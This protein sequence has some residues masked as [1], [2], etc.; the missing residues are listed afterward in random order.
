[1]VDGFIGPQYKS[2]CLNLNYY[3]HAHDMDL[4]VLQLV[5]LTARNL[6]E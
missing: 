4:E 1:M 6:K 3:P 2:T 5:S